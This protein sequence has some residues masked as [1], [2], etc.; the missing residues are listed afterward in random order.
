MLY[1]THL[2]S[3]N[4]CIFILSSSLSLLLLLCC[5]IGALLSPSPASPLVISHKCHART[6]ALCWL[7]RSASDTSTYMYT[8]ESKVRLSALGVDERMN[9]FV[10]T[11][12]PCS[13]ARLL[14]R[15]LLLLTPDWWVP[16]ER[17]GQ[18][19]A[20]AG[21][22]RNSSPTRCHKALHIPQSRAV[23][24]PARLLGNVAVVYCAVPGWETFA[25]PSPS[26]YC[27]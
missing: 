10:N 3:V 1:D 9:P 5:C 8:V 21:R 20:P 26:S 4:K 12:S 24:P 2:L 15:G 17:E 13:T 22:T 23:S 27:Y 11:R 14:D 6:H 19:E 16:G 25:S 7:I 18:C